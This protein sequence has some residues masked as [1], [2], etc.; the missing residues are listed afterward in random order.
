[1][2]HVLIEGRNAVL[3]ALRSGVPLE[4]VYLTDGV[5]ESQDQAGVP[6]EIVRMARAGRIQVDFVSKRWLDERSERGAHQGTMAVLA[7]FQFTPLAS[8]LELAKDRAGSLL[9]ALDHVTDAGNFGAIARSAEVAG[10]DGL[11]VTKRRSAPITGGAYKTSAGALAWLP[12]AQETNLVRALEACKA[13]G[14][15]IVGASEHADGSIWDQPMEGRLVIVLGSEGEGLARL[16]AEACDFTAS[17]PVAGHV[18]SLNVAQAAAVF[19]YE[20]VR[21]GRS[22]S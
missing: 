14:Y 7:P 13:A 12:I 22:A 8:I 9:V 16:T 5:R 18:G 21:R 19:M 4:R 15:W 17:L 6:G 20:W 2:S 1:M 11:I 3:E 10:A